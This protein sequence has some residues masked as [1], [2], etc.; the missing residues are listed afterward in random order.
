[1]C[2]H[3]FSFFL[4][5]AGDSNHVWHSLIL[6]QP[7]LNKDWKKLLKVCANTFDTTKQVHFDPRLPTYQNILS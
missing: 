1:M 2:F 6:T 7:N 3:I 5:T 4:A